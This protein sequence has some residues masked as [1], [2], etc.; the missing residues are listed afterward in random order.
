MTFQFELTKTGQL[1]KCADIPR[2]LVVPT[3]PDLTRIAA[4]V[5]E[6]M[7]E[8]I[9]N[10]PL[11][12]SGINEASQP[13]PTRLLSV[14]SNTSPTIRLLH[15]SGK[16]GRYA[17]LSHC[18]G[19]SQPL[20][21]TR[22]SLAAHCRSISM[23]QL[24]K[25]FLDAV[26]VTRSL[27][28]QYLWIDSLAILQDDPDDWKR[29]AVKMGSVYGNAYI[30]I[31]ASRS[32]SSDSGFLGLRTQDKVVKICP[33]GSTPFHI[34]LRHSFADDTDGAPL[35]RRAWVLQEMILSQRI[36]HFTSTQMYWDCWTRHQGEDLDNLFLGV[37]KKDA[38]PPSLAPGTNDDD[39]HTSQKSNTPRQWWHLLSSYTGCELT[40]QSDKLIAIS[41]LVERITERTGQK[42]IAGYFE[43]RLHEGLLW[44][45]CNFPFEHRPE[46][47]LPSWSWASRKGRINHVQLYSWAVN[48]KLRLK[49]T[50]L[51]STAVLQGELRRLRLNVIYSDMKNA[52]SNPDHFFPYELDYYSTNFRHVS[53]AW[54]KDTDEVG[55]LTLDTDNGQAV[56]WMQIGWV[57]VACNVD[58]DE[59]VNKVEVCADVDDATCNTVER[60]AAAKEGPFYCMLVRQKAGNIYERV[61]IGSIGSLSWFTD[62]RT[63]IVI[64]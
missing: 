29:E 10:H 22:A 14:G 23:N 61:G 18:W 5:D 15:T 6:W 8:C 58:T 11:C 21:T 59:E 40:Y 42:S 30:T 38:Y 28:L 35:A 36:L 44:S 17:A 32:T 55:W 47:H 9:S 37:F 43:D 4:L 56:D 64:A 49:Y 25:T 54:L 24:P 63:D 31:A 34:G 41:G 33:S 51:D 57:V 45:A 7:H 12:N 52:A 26:H 19:P 60:A 2:G 46:L 20:K 13:F 1:N 62:D 39:H 50:G 16:Q 27:G 3:S 53:P 48:D